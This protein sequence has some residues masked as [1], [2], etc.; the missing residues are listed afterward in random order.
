MKQTKSKKLFERA[1]KIIPGG[2]NS[3]VRAFR[4]VGLNP[5]FIKKANRAYLWDADGNRFVDYVGSW[6]PMI[7]GHAHPKISRVLRQTLNHGTSFGAPTDLEVNM[8][9]L[10]TRLMPSVEMVRMVNS[11]TEATMSAIRLA[12]AYTGRE[13]IIKFEGGYH[14]H[15]DAF[16]IRAGSGAMTHGT[17]DSP[18]VT[19]STASDTLNA[20]F[21]DAGSVREL[22][23]IHAGSIAALIIEPVAGNMGCVPPKPGFLQEL[24][25]IC[26]S[27]KIVLILDEVI[28]GF[29]VAPGGAQEKFGIR[30]DLTTLGKII[31]GGLPVGAYG[32]KKQIMELVSPSGPVY[33]AGTLSGNPLAMAAG[34]ETLSILS[35]QPSIY[36]RLERR[37]KELEAGLRECLQRLGVAHQINRAGS[38][39]TLFFTGHEVVDYATAKT[40]DTGIFARY[41]REM[42]ARGIYLPPSQFEAAFVSAAHG[43]LEIERTLRAHRAALAAAL[44]SKK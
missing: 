39:F 36:S 12:R 32:G 40:S 17:P 3:P 41:F 29:R 33:Q 24:R 18:G 8:A 10:I 38:M 25:E 42:L 6:G 19:K 44:S 27:K 5:P 37:S 23:R 2:V 7:L 30:G 11:G 35:R 43:D 15:A 20:R 14:G 4:N 22:L 21:N 16:L 13:K 26:T 31:G 34:R 1:K 9:E 28:T